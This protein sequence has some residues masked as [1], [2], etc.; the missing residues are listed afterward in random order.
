MA[1]PNARTQSAAAQ[2]S[3]WARRFWI[4]LW[5][6]MFLSTGVIYLQRGQAADEPEDV[7]IPVPVK[8]SVGEGQILTGKIAL[9]TSVEH[10]EALRKREPRLRSVIM[11]SLAESFEGASRPKLADVSRSL[12]EAVNAALPR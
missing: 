12:L 4:A 9:V 8:M 7:Y 11:A 10:E 1:R 6:I 5:S 3:R 2:S